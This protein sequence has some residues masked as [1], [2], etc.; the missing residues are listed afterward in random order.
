MQIC[1][2]NILLK[3]QDAI[4]GALLNCLT[5]IDLF[6][7]LPSLNAVVDSCAE[8][9]DEEGFVFLRSDLEAVVRDELEFHLVRHEAP[10]FSSGIKTELKA[11]GEPVELDEVLDFAFS[12][13]VEEIKDLIQKYG[14]REAVNYLERIGGPDRGYFYAADSDPDAVTHPGTESVFSQIK[15]FLSTL[16]GLLPLRGKPCVFLREVK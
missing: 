12:N 14:E 2:S 11:Q 13:C 8:S 6:E 5:L 16:Q 9:L 1:D 3:D 10:W 7:T 4:F 15:N